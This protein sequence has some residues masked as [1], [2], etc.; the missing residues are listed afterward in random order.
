METC[1]QMRRYDTPRPVPNGIQSPWGLCVSQAHVSLGFV[2][3]TDVPSAESCSLNQI[4]ECIVTCSDVRCEEAMAEAIL[5]QMIGPEV[6]KKREA[7]PTC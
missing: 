3:V 1:A 5:A 4:G 6:A 7:I 2:C